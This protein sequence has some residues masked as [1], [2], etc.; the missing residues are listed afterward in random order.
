MGSTLGSLAVSV[1]LDVRQLASGIQK[2]RDEMGRFAKKMGES[3]AVAEKAMGGTGSAARKMAD[4]FDSL[5]QIGADAIGDINAGL[6]KMVPT[7][8]GAAAAARGLADSVESMA[9]GAAKKVF[10]IG[11]M[12]EAA[13][14][15]ISGIG[16][17]ITNIGGKLSLGV[18]APITA[19]G[20]AAV[21]MSG[22]LEQSQVAFTTM[23]GSAEAAGSYIKDLQQ[24]A[25]TTPFEFMGVQDG[26]QK[27]MAY[28]FAAKDVIPTLT[29]IGDNLSAF[30]KIS[31]DSMGRA[32]RALGQMKSSGTVM[33]EDLNQLTEIGLNVSSILQ[34][35]LGLTAKQVA[36][37]GFEQIESQKV[38]NAILEG[39]AERFGGSMAKQSQTLLGL[40]ST[41]KDNANLTLAELGNDIVKSL[42]LK[43]RLNE[44]VAWMGE[45]LTWFRNLDE[46]SKTAAIGVGIFAASLG[47]G[48]VLVGQITVALGGLVT[49]IGFIATPMGLVTVGIVGFVAAMGQALVQS[50]VLRDNLLQQWPQIRAAFGDAW[51]GIQ[52]IFRGVQAAMS[53]DWATFGTNM[54]KGTEQ[55]GASIKKVWNIAMDALL[56]VAEQ[57]L[58]K[59][60]EWLTNRIAQLP[61]QIVSKAMEGWKALLGEQAFYAFASD[62][63]I[64]RLAPHKKAGGGLLT[65]PG[66]GTSDSIPALLSNGEF[67][68]PAAATARNLPLLEAMR[69]NRFAGGGAVGGGMG[70]ASGYGMGWGYSPKNQAELEAELEALTA[71]YKRNLVTNELADAK[72]LD[73]LRATTDLTA[74]FSELASI[75]QSVG[76]AIAGPVMNSVNSFSD[77]IQTTA[78]NGL[79][80]FANATGAAEKGFEWLEKPD[81]ADAWAYATETV[82]DAGKGVREFADSAIQAAESVQGAVGALPGPGDLIPPGASDFE[83][84]IWG[85][86]TPEMQRH[87]ERMADILQTTEFKIEV[88]GETMA[89]KIKGIAGSFVANVEGMFPSL[90]NSQKL[91]DAMNKSAWSLQNG[92]TFFDFGALK[93]MQEGNLKLLAVMERGTE[94][95]YEEQMQELIGTSADWVASLQENRTVMGMATEGQYAAAAAT[96]TMSDSL[97]QASQTASMGLAAAGEG[98]LASAAA[99]AGAG[100]WMAN[101]FLAN[102][103]VVSH[104]AGAMAQGFAA[105]TAGVIGAATAAVAAVGA[106]LGQIGMGSELS[107]LERQIQNG[108]VTRAPESTLPG[109][110]PSGLNTSGAGFVSGGNWMFDSS[111]R[112]V[113]AGGYGALPPIQIDLNLDGQQIHSALIGQ[114][115]TYNGA[116][117]MGGF[118]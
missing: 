27:L 71:A 109:G 56:P 34:E 24:F 32:I 10:E 43:D 17:E 58:T 72:A 83:K 86:I 57:A 88:A 45:F 76:S 95:A 100:Q 59:L 73:F 89:Q 20:Y 44:A 3:A 80:D 92:N 82:K 13:G 21:N 4:E 84:S 97:I 48:L 65:G 2:S 41:F 7:A 70:P 91:F 96:Q 9:S 15:K 74:D 112:R 55:L 114:A 81:A 52:T 26:A 116:N 85:G 40:W 75:A 102:G 78:E 18:T 67:V 50:Q 14:K 104:A 8:K 90:K 6:S 79:Y 33:K 53:G 107:D 39:M 60:I 51:G 115:Q 94:G 16:S 61:G 68:M 66:T 37:I 35:K 93:S 22:Q 42:N 1:G 63:D 98:A 99:T 28:G 106:Q 49:V 64:A 30:G 54:V 11:A 36:N 118:Y 19:L 23:L 108:G 69:A 103:M 47:P 101:T 12:V 87:Q 117:P 77:A 31:E 111:G 113:R 46:G 62:E 29:A 110:N 38:I 105:A 5:G 25:A